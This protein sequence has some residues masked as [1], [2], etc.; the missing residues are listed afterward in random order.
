M[1]PH[2]HR[3]SRTWVRVAYCLAV[4]LAAV[5]LVISIIS[6]NVPLALCSLVLSLI[7]T[8][9]ADLIGTRQ[10]PAPVTHTPPPPSSH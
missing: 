5:F 6:W 1:S 4:V 8:R 2:D 3:G 9:N 10:P 7:L